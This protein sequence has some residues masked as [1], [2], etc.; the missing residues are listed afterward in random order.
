V[1]KL[2]AV[3]LAIVR[4]PVDLFGVLIRKRRLAA[5][6]R[7]DNFPL[8]AGTASASLALNRRVTIVVRY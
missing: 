2:V 5:I 7:A 4:L 1:R 6:G 8:V 3:L